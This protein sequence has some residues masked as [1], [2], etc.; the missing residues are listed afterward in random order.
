MNFFKVIS[1]DK[2]VKPFGHYSQ[3]I[4]YNDLIFVSMQL[5][6]S[7]QH[8]NQVGTIEEQTIQALTNV[9]AILEE[10]GSSLQKVLK[11]TVYVSDMSSWDSINAIYVDFFKTHRPAR[12]VVPSGTFP[13]GF[14]VGFDVIASV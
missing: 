8:P 6:A 3:A 9:E 1:T 4:V 13:K 12:A 2:A 14:Q 11:V 10:A 7:P 5:G